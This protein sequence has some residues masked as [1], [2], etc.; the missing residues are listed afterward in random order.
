M[1]IFQFNGN[2][3]DSVLDSLFEDIDKKELLQEL[4]ECGLEVQSNEKDK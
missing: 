4:I 1:N 3:F 2:E